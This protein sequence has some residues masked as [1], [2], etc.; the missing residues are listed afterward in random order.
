[1]ALN[2]PYRIQR[3]KGSSLPPTKSGR[4]EFED[5]FAECMYAACPC[6]HVESEQVGDYLYKQSRCNKDGRWLELGSNRYKIEK[7][8]QK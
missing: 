4:L 6:Y 7:E 8:N 3:V 5:Q 2:C 1:M